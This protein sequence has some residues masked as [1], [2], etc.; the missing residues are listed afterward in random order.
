MQNK[1]NETE[2]QKE[3]RN[4]NKK[5]K[6]IAIMLV[7][8]TI[9]VIGVIIVFI[10]SLK[11]EKQNAQNDTCTEEKL[12]NKQTLESERIYLA[13]TQK[14]QQKLFAATNLKTSPYFKKWKRFHITIGG[15]DKD[16]AGLSA[17]QIAQEISDTAKLQSH[18]LWKVPKI[19][20]IKM[21]GGLQ[22]MHLSPK[23][24]TLTSAVQLLKKKGW[25]NIKTNFHV[26]L[27]ES[28]LL[29]PANIA[30][31]TSI[32]IDKKDVMK[33]EWVSVKETNKTQIIWDQSFPAFQF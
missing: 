7:C 24:T 18:I 5:K 23:D 4:N 33:W 32:F 3:S 2:E 6:I 8:V 19:Q 15:F 27:G 12:I 13:P 1:I 21:Q 28:N 30:A 10:L 14:Y 20:G 11:I 29:T 25:K 17:A 31:L 22:I 9:I 26:T 16:N